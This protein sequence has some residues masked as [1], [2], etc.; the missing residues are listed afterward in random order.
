MHYYIFNSS[1]SQGKACRGPRLVHG[2]VHKVTNNDLRRANIYLLKLLTVAVPC[3]FLFQDEA[4]RFLAH[5]DSDR[6]ADKCFKKLLLLFRK[7]S[8]CIP[9]FPI[10]LDYRIIWIPAKIF[11]MNR[12][13]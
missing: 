2:T 6:S 7:H 11:Q 10:I 3:N 1:K 8:E 13:V 5:C 9:K 12:A 4:R